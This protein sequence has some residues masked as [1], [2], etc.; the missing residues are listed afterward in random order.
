MS[1]NDIGYQTMYVPY[2]QSV[3]P[4]G[5]EQKKSNKFIVA[6]VF[7][8]LVLLLLF[9]YYER[10]HPYILNTTFTPPTGGE[11]HRTDTCGMIENGDT[12]LKGDYLINYKGNVLL[13]T[14][15]DVSII[16]RNGELIYSIG[17]DTELLNSYTTINL[18]EF[19][20]DCS[21]RFK[22]VGTFDGEQK[23]IIVE[24]RDVFNEFRADGSA[25]HTCL[26]KPR[27]TRPC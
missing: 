3:Y 5:Y 13:V 26:F 12:F 25:R 16:G 8:T 19:T 24:N 11:K 15:D 7:M 2:R 9:I 4:P 18:T 27:E 1:T 22:I 6:I 21:H 23:I 14:S 10:Y 17:R 20:Y